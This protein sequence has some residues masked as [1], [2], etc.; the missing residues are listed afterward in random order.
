[1]SRIEVLAET[2]ANQIAAG[3]VIERPAAVVK[4]LCENALDAGARRVEVDLSEGGCA[5]VRVRDDGSGMA[6]DDARKSLERHATS[7]LRS[8]EDLFRISTYGFRGEALPSIAA[9]SRFTLL[10]CEHGALSGTRIEIEGGRLVSAAE[11][12]APPGT[13][14]R[15]GISSSTFRRGRSS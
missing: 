4:E 11:A 2:L 9:V 12:G 10:S 13:T 7:K 3:E 14:V 15:R 5:V 8:K 6:P 1:M